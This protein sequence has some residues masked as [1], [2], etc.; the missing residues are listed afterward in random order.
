M[1]VAT[2]TAQIDSPASNIRPF[3]RFRKNLIGIMPSLVGNSQE[4]MGCASG[5]QQRAHTA[6]K[7]G[8]PHSA[9]WLYQKAAKR[10]KL[11]IERGDTDERRSAQSQLD[12]CIYGL[13]KSNLSLAKFYSGDPQLRMGHCRKSISL[14]TELKGSLEADMHTG[15]PIT[16]KLVQK[17]NDNMLEA[18]ALI[19]QVLG[20]NYDIGKK[21]EHHDAAFHH[22]QSMLKLIASYGSLPAMAKR[23][24][25]TSSE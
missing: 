9:V 7:K 18:S 4:L 23:Y 17:I 8:R 15:K 2:I 11:V 12:S 16:K 19:L 10:Y 20:R 6:R 3:A 13:A 21:K 22:M 14:F 5:F 1:G 25:A 24:R